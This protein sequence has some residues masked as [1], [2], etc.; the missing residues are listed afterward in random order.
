[1]INPVLPFLKA[2]M[3]CSTTRFLYKVP[4]TLLGF[5]P[6]GSAEN[7]IPLSSVA[8]VSTSVKF[9]PG[10][11]LLTLI[12]AIAGLSML[13]SAL[14]GA[15]VLLVV[16]VLFGIN[17][18]SSSLIVTNHAGGASGLQVCVLDSNN[19]KLFRQ[20]LQNR[21]FADKEAVRHQEAQDL[22]QQQ[23]MAQQMQTMMMQ[24]MNRNQNGKSDGQ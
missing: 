22:R 17:S 4:N 14:A 21:V 20:E 10:R 2:Q 9:H 5:I 19:L 6:I 15:L 13:S 23:L 8:S 3:M 11:A 16:A 7:T 1:M 12:C 24:Q 18:V